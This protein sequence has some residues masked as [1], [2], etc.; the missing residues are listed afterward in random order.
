[1]TNTKHDLIHS[2]YYGDDCIFLLEDLTNKIIPLSVEEKEAYIRAGGNYA[3]VI[4]KEDSFDDHIIEIFK[5]LTLTHA[6]Q[7]ADYVGIIC[8][9]LYKKY[10][11]DMVFV[12]LAR[13][14]SPVGVLMKHYMLW[15]YGSDIPHYSI[16]IVRDRGIDENALDDIRRQ[17][18]EKELCF[19]DGWT[20]RGSITFELKK[21]V[22]QYN[23][24]RSAHLNSDLIVLMDPAHLSKIAATKKR[25]LSTK[26]MFEFYDLW[27]SQSYNFP[28]KQK[29]RS[30]SWCDFIKRIQGSGLYQLVHSE[31]FQKIS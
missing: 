14:G 9:H 21:A 5:E 19:I 11:N 18:P 10:G 2:T 13:A 7:I 16:S 17:H 4:S 22:E 29:Q 6:Y 23:Q 24:S 15:R 12:S 8:N 31:D 27:I 26:C 30:L 28:E 1:M 20:G 3:E 25:Y